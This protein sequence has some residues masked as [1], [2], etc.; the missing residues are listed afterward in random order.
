VSLAADQF[1]CAIICPAGPC[2]REARDLLGR[3][4]TIC[5]RLTISRK[6]KFTRHSKVAGQRLHIFSQRTED[7]RA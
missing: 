1:L 2:G 4:P 5:C 3:D 7:V 6:S